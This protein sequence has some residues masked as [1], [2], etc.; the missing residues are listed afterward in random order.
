MEDRCGLVGDRRKLIW[1]D[2][3]RVERVMVL[4]HYAFN[5]PQMLVEITVPEAMTETV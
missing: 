3:E 1:F 4:K 5:V 2:G